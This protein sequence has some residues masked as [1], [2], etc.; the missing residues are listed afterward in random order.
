M[1]KKSNPLTNEI[2]GTTDL[3]IFSNLEFINRRDDDITAIILCIIKSIRKYSDI[4]GAQV[5]LKHE[6]G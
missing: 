2:S 5:M 1:H 3:L 4:T 6:I